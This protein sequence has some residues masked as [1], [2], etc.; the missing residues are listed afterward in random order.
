MASEKEEFVE[1]GQPAVWRSQKKRPEANEMLCR[2]MN[3]KFSIKVR[4]TIELCEL[5]GPRGREGLEE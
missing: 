4:K 2:Q 3:A 1:T 5:Y